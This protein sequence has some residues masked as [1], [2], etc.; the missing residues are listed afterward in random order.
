MAYEIMAFVLVSIDLY[1]KRYK[2]KKGPNIVLTGKYAFTKLQIFKL[3]LCG[4]FAH[5]IS[6]L[7]LDFMNKFY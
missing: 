5:Y 7:L 3:I 6:L 4:W 1:K 2:I